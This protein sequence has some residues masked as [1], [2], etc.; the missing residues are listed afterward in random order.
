MNSKATSSKADA[1]GGERDAFRKAQLPGTEEQILEAAIRCVKKWGME[2]VTLNDIATE[3]GVAR[4]TVYKYYT[5][6]DDVLRAALLQ[7]AYGFG[8]R[9][10][11][12]IAQLPTPGEKLIEAVVYGIKT[13][14]EEPSLM[15]L[16]D[17][18]LSHLV[19]E[20][21]LTTPQ[22]L[23]MGTA[24]MA[25]ILGEGKY[26]AEE[27]EEISETAMRFMLSQVSMKSP[28]ARTEEQLRG[29]VARRLLPAIGL[30]VPERYQSV[31]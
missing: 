20:H 21:S 13:L 24:M 10:V 29:F 31:S 28:K 16:S 25:F 26:S 4:S 11:E 8:L 15:L 30:P 19:S 23:D 6:R 9:L 7:S 3:A 22:G 2:R 12:H 1:A 27:M 18:A 14:P 17:S 5:N